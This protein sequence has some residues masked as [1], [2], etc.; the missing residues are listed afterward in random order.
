MLN[1]KEQKVLENIR[2]QKIILPILIG[3]GVVFYLMWRQFDADE[4]NKINWNFHV[5]IWVGMAIF[6]YVLRH[7]FYAWRLRIWTEKQFSWNKSIELIFIWEFATSVSPTSIG[8]AAVALVLLAQE[9]ISGSKTVSIVLY[10]VVVD[11]L[12]LFISIPLLYWIIGPNIIRP[13]MEASLGSN[14]YAYTLLIILLVMGFYGAIFF[15]GLFI[16][17]KQLKRFLLM[18]SKVRWLKK[19]RR[20]LRNTAYD[21]VISSKELANKPWKFHAN[22]GLSTVGAWTAR[23]LAINC[24]IIALTQ[25][26]ATNFWDQLVIFGRGQILYAITAF[27]PTPGAAGVAELFFGGFFSDYISRSVAVLAAFFWRFITY[28]PYLIIGVIIIP[29]WIRKIIN[30][31]KAEKAIQE[32]NPDQNS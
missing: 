15:Y 7:L 29:N 16:N 23:F 8:G 11:T 25:L 19:F 4:F 30:R 21:V 1:S 12:F 17:P 24:L 9:K 32:I 10:S 3:V 13:G 2:V 20:N 27:S 6:M 31:R 26:P 14:G 18:L 28:Y 5:L 22:V